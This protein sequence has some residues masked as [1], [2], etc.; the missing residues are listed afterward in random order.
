[1]LRN[2]ID[3]DGEAVASLWRRTWI[4]T[5]AGLPEPEP[6]PH[7][8][9]RLTEECRLGREILVCEHQAAIVAFMIVDP[10]S[11]HITQLF[12]DVSHQGC[13]IGR[14]LLDEMKMRFP[15]GWSLN[16]MADNRR[17][18]ALYER[19]GL[20]RGRTSLSP[21]SR[22]ERVAFVWAPESAAGG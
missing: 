10:A 5:H 9:D 12:V 14:S 18:I 2:F 22:R 1:M 19:Y 13:G 16:V 7:W 17:A 20:T 15:D 11:A 6:L 8:K 4:A 21:V 3:E